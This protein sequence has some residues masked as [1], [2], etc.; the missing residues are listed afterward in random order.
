MSISLWS[1]LNVAANSFAK[2][3][4]MAPSLTTDQLVGSIAAIVVSV[5]DL[6]VGNAVCVPATELAVLAGS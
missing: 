3:T 5:T 6:G 4:L 1:I 2:L